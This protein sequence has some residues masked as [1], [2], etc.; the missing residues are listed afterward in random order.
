MDDDGRVDLLRALEL[1]E[2]EVTALDRLLAIG[3]TTAPNLAEATDIPKA[4]IYGVL[5]SLADEGFVEIIPGRPKEYQPKPP[6]EIL[7]RAKANRRQ[8]YERYC[9]DV[10]GIAEPFLDRY[11]P[12]YERAS[13]EVNPTRELFHV[14][15][16]GEPSL[17]ETREI[18][19]GATET[20]QIMTKSFEYLD[21]VAVALGDAVDRGVEVRVLFLHPGHLAAENGRIQTRIIERL[22]A[23]FPGVEYRFS[24]QPMPWRGALADPSM[25]YETGTA[26][27]L[28]EE[29]DVPL[30]MRQAAVTEN[31][32]FV[33][34]MS[35]YFTLV[36]DH[37]SVAEPDP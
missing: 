14:V 7:E 10:E 36:W 13:E 6:E 34:G 27:F 8:R 32:S 33:A 5:E 16:V 30:H 29:K 19:R 12:L 1:K 35:R 9:K 3:R 15:D 21:D 22:E 20:L 24:N 31:G 25:D 28:V 4:R 37:D 23:D 11:G 18:Y 26:I 17:Q 2:Y